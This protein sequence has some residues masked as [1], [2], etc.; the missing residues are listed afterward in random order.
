MAMLFT[1]ILAIKH[2]LR[3]RQICF[4]CYQYREPLVYKYTAVPRFQLDS[5]HNTSA[6]ALMRFTKTEIDI[7]GGV[8]LLMSLSRSPR[9][10][11]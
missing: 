4:H 1:Q 8:G 11:L 9:L 10:L 5:V 3:R 7:T 6:C 2:R